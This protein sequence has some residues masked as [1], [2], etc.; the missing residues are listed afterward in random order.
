MGVNRL[1]LV[2]HG[3][4]RANLTKE[5]SYRSVDYPL[6]AKGRLQAEQT[7]AYLKRFPVTQVFASPLKRA[8]ETA[9]IIASAVGGEVSLL[10][11]FRELNVGALEAQPPTVA[12]WKQHDEVIWAWAEGDHE[13]RFPEG[14]NYHELAFRVRRGYEAMCRNRDGETL[15][16][17]A[18]GG[19]LSLPL[20]SL[21]PELDAQ[22]LQ[23][24]V[25]HNC[26]VGELEASFDD[27]LRLKLVRWASADHLYGEAAAFVAA[28]PNEGDLE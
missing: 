26:A 14:E 4:N 15:V 18:H 11:P 16:L 2:R 28:T 24:T 19:S 3:E 10:E 17:V 23:R 6:T 27:V 12:A 8:H 7:A 9:E 20:L 1:F 5:F 21:V 22:L 25:H 13:A